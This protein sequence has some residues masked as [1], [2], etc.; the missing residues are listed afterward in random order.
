MMLLGR[1]LPLVAQETVWEIGPRSLPASVGVSEVFRESLLKTPVPD[2]AAA[3]AIVLRTD[4][5]WEAWAREGDVPSAATAR[6]LAEAL[7]VAIREDKIAGVKVYRVM[8]SEVSKRHEKHL[9]VYI[10]ECG[11]SG[12]A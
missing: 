6:R 4:E 1:S 11:R 3:K 2:V 5:Q 7:S 9:F 12:Y 8:P 10:H